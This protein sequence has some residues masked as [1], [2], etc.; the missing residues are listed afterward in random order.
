MKKLLLGLLALGTVLNVNASVIGISN[1][2]L[3]MNKHIVTTELDSFVSDG[4]GTG[5]MARYTYNANER[6]KFD[7]GFG[8]TDG[9]RSSRM[10]L[11]ADMMLIPDYG[12]QPKA[13]IKGLMISEE[14]DG[15][16]YNSFGAAPTLAKGIVIG[17]NE[18]YP[19]LALPMTVGLNADDNTYETTMAVAT[20]ITGNL[21]VGGMRDVIGSFEANFPID[22]SY[23]AFVMGLSIPIQ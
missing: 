23:T 14:I 21:N 8:F 18:A 22:N 7:A 1:Q 15:V 10:V 19:F 16:R 5:V 9:D 3:T 20:G 13:S 6:L 11:G 12:R 2:P 4:T 17:G